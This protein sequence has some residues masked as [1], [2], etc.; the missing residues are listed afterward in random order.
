M[1]Q[2]CSSSATG[3]PFGLIISPVA[4]T[5]EGYDARN[6]YHDW[7]LYLFSMHRKHVHDSLSILW[8]YCA[9]HRNGNGG[10]HT[11][12]DGR[13]DMGTAERLHS[14]YP[15]MKELVGAGELV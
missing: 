14:G 4:S 9:N 15:S 1:G 3:A 8:L 2:H 5:G 11:L 6:W 7:Y 12:G 10:S 13:G